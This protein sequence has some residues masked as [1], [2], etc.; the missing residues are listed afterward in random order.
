MKN[1]YMAI[2]C[3][4][5]NGKEWA[6]V[7]KFNCAENVASFM[8]CDDIVAANMMPTKKD[9]EKCVDG[10]NEIFIKRDTFAFA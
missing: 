1:F 7:R 2:M 8:Q 5:I 3:K 10:W 4:D 9:A 6:Y